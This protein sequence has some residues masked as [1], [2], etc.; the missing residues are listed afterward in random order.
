MI[1]YRTYLVSALIAVFG[2]LEATDW[3]ALLDNPSAGWVAVGA[4]VVMAIMRSIT[5]T[6]AGK[7]LGK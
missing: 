1:G 5:T 4:A 2:V 7:I 6:P 3:N